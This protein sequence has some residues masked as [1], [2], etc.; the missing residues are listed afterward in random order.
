MLTAQTWQRIAAVALTAWLGWCGLAV[1]AQ[2]P[3]ITTLAET[4]ENA[5]RASSH[6]PEPESVPQIRLLVGAVRELFLPQRILN[7]SAVVPEVAGVA[8]KPPGQLIITALAIGETPV[9][10]S[11]E[12]RRLTFFVTVEPQRVFNLAEFLAREGRRAKEGEAETR[13]SYSVAYTPP[14]G[15]DA[16]YLQQSVSIQHKLGP[17][18]QL[19]AEAEFFNFLGGG[20]RD[21]LLRAPEARFGVNR[22][23]LGVD[24]KNKGTLDFLDSDLQISRLN[25]NNY[26]LRGLHYRAAETMTRWRGTELFAGAAQP[27]PFGL[28]G[29]QGFVA[30]GVVPIWP[31]KEKN[32]WRVRAGA[33]ALFPRSDARRNSLLRDP[34]AT[35]KALVLHTDAL[36]TPHDRLNVEFAGNFAHGSFSGYARANARTKTLTFN[37]EA[38]YTARKSPLGRVGAQSGGTQLATALVQW[39]PNQ[40]WAL[41]GSFYRNASDLQSLGLGG[42]SLSGQGAAVNV[43]FTPRPQSR[44]SF[45]YAQNRLATTLNLT[46]TTPLINTAQAAQAVSANYSE[47]RG[48]LTNDIA[49]RFTRQRDLQTQTSLETSF[50]LRDELRRTYEHG[51]VAGFAV[52]SRQAP[53]LAALLLQRPDLLPVSLR[54]ALRNN[55]RNFLAQ[56]STAELL[57]LSNLDREARRQ[58]NSLEFGARGQVG[59]QDLT[60]YGEARYLGGSLA[61]RSQSNLLFTSSLT[62]RADAANVFSVQAIQYQSFNANSTTR[63]SLTF[64][65]TYYFG[66]GLAPAPAEWLG[67]TRLVRGLSGSIEGRVFYDANGNGVYDAGEVGAPQVT[68][69]LDGGART[70]KTDAAGRYRFDKVATG[71]HTAALQWSALGAT[72]RAVTPPEM[73]AEVSRKPAE[74]SFAVTDRGFIAGRVYN[75][76]GRANEAENGTGLAGVAVSLW[77][78]DAVSRA[79]TPLGTR[80]TLTDGKF[81]FRNLA[82]GK[83]R[84]AW[85]EAT[86]PPN[87]RIPATLEN[88]LTV[89]PLQ[90]VYAYLPVTAQR[91]VSGIVFLDLDDDGIFDPQKDTPLAGARVTTGASTATTSANGTYLLRDLPTGALEIRAVTAEGIAATPQQV[92]LSAEP[93]TLRGVNLPVKLTIRG[94]QK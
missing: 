64:S 47:T 60:F 69:A 78:V 86:L 82:P 32:N 72:V 42:A 54:T 15:N 38:L 70:V 44:L 27:A 23:A 93:I 3:T 83:Y 87:Y 65:Y 20:G 92:E 59:N 2:S 39:R 58:T 34:D 84:V 17:D 81:E 30:G 14:V 79:E 9:I 46:Q 5:A 12:G 22:F 45:S 13:G 80:N 50:A 28:M 49:I 94:R 19:R 18:R 62:W 53:T 61:G 10:V 67:V 71:P 11:I 41:F 7:A 74:V 66:V 52:Y 26:V 24:D 16:A 76:L 88:V 4:P 68:V 35:K 29:Q 77:V 1:Q 55:P 73:N 85:D 6:N 57:A 75:A 48:Q 36:Y 21:A 8:V 51:Y 56:Y 31:K 91:A 63:T 40:R 25:F 33:F 43:S 89:A 37:G 90:A